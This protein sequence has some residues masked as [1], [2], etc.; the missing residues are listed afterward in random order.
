LTEGPKCL[1]L[2]TEVFERTL[3]VIIYLKSDKS[4]DTE[5]SRNKDKASKTSKTEKPKKKEILI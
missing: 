5:N 4:K 1:I 2:A 3:S